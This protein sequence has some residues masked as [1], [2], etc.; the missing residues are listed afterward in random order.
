MTKPEILK[1]PEKPSSS[2]YCS[3]S[4]SPSNSSSSSSSNHQINL[5]KV[6]VQEN[7]S[8]STST[9]SSLI[10]AVKSVAFD[11]SY[12]WIKVTFIHYCIIYFYY[13]KFIII[14]III[15][16]R[17]FMSTPYHLMVHNHITNI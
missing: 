13:Y 8:S 17:G 2:S 4:I 1:N 12:Y 9:L 11:V 7:V 5:D 15:D 14:V 10:S 16:I 3:Y 6:G